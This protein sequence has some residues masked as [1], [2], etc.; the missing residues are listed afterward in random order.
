MVDNPNQ[1]VYNKIEHEECSNL[2]TRAKA[3]KGN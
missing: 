3:Q 2:T 1:I